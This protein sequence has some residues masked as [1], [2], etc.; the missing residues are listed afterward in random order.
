MGDLFKLIKRGRYHVPGY[1]SSEAKD[2]IAQMLNVDRTQRISIEGIKKHSWFAQDLPPD[3]LESGIK[4]KHDKDVKEME[5]DGDKSIENASALNDGEKSMLEFS[6]VPI[7]STAGVFPTATK[8][9]KSAISLVVSPFF[10]GVRREASERW[11][12]CYSA[13]IIRPIR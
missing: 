8:K 10:E 3:P 6:L 11:D 12:R 9:C 5:D 4:E 2:L 13:D 7:L 1:V